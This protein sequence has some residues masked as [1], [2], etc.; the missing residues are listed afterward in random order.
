MKSVVKV[1]KT[2]EGAVEEALEELGVNRDDV[3]VEVLEQPSRG[4][5]GFIGTRDAVVKVIVSNDPK[6]IIDE[7]IDKVLSTM[8]IV[9]KCDIEKNGDIYTVDLVGIENKDVGIIIGRRGATLD[10]IQ[11]LLSLAIN[12]GRENYIRVVLDI[13][14]YRGKREKTLVKLAEKMAY[15]AKRNKS[16]AKLEPMNPYERRIIHSALQDEENITTFSEGEDPYRRVVIKY[17]K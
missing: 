8:N 14:D 7:F 11:Y 15:K 4:L 2:I 6:Q 9:G 3:E 5:L 1:S 13:N 10:A 12:E 16:V 17:K